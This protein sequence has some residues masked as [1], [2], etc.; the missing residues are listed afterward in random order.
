MLGSGDSTHIVKL[1]GLPFSTSVE[2]VLDFLNGVNVINGK[3]GNNPVLNFIH[4]S[5]FEAELYQYDFKRFN[6]AIHDSK[7]YVALNFLKWSSKILNKIILALKQLVV[8]KKLVVDS[9]A[10]ESG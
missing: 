5:C 9:Q 2:D 7:K 4:K 8:D 3:E 6:L 1:R 10:V